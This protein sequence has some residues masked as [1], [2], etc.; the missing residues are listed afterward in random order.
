M[1]FPTH[2]G[3]GTAGDNLRAPAFRI[4]VKRTQFI[5]RVIRIN[6]MVMMTPTKTKAK[7]KKTETNTPTMTAKVSNN[8]IDGDD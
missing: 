5:H 7:G 3:S 6:T 1:V 8:Y 2:R 4:R